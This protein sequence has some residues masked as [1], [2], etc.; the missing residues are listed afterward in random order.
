MWS[1]LT[2]TPNTIVD[3]FWRRSWKHWRVVFSH[4][5]GLSWGHF[6]QKCLKL[7]RAR[8]IPTKT[9]ALWTEGPFKQWSIRELYISTSIPGFSQNLE[10]HFPDNLFG[11]HFRFRRFQHL[12]SSPMVGTIPWKTAW[13]KCKCNP[14]LFPGGRVTCT[15]RVPA[16]LR[17]LY[18]KHVFFV[19]VPQQNVQHK[20]VVM[21][22]DLG[23][24][25]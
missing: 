3:G 10:K 2:L 11:L 18:E 23:N 8:Q 4:R 17:S 6:Q 20:K 13:Q 16:L 5:L 25:F 12:T 15:K 21:H 1:L 19:K 9:M 7:L 14:L 22:V 24:L